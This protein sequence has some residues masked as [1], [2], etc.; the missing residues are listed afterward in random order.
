MLVSQRSILLSCMDRMTGQEVRDL[1]Y[2]VWKDPLAWMET[3]KGKRWENML[4]REKQHFHEL[5]TQR[6]VE[7][8]TKKM[9]QEI[10]DSNSI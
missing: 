10:K 6:S 1:G 2:I 7:R 3:M 9:E 5:S 8:E 4:Q